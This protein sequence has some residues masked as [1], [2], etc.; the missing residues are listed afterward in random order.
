MY[1]CNDNIV[2]ERKGSQKVLGTALLESNVN[3]WIDHTCN[4][5]ASAESQYSC[6]W[7]K[8]SREGLQLSFDEEKVEH[9]ACMLFRQE[10]ADCQA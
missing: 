6:N 9:M 8:H 5:M 4:S 10:W 3:H 1:G 7:A 2:L